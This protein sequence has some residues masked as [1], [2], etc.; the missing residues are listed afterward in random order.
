METATA[1]RHKMGVTREKSEAWIKVGTCSYRVWLHDFLSSNAHLDPKAII[2]CTDIPELG[3]N[4][5]SNPCYTF[6]YIFR[7]SMSRVEF[8]L[9]SLLSDQ[10]IKSHPTRFHYLSR[11]EVLWKLVFTTVLAELFLSWCVDVV[12]NKLI[13]WTQISHWEGQYDTWRFHVG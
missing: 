9:K 1:E 11:K 4:C 6:S 3:E 5:I 13:F 12:Q 10:Y 2:F 8:K 7:S